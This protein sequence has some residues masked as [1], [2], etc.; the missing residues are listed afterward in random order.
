MLILS[1]DQVPA[2]PLP[3]TGRLAGVDVGIA[4]FATTSDGGPVH[5]PRWARAA[6]TRLT[7]AQH[8]LA[9]AKCGS[10]NRGR[11]LETVAARHRK[12]ANQRRDFHHKT[13]RIL[14]E[15]YDL[16]VVEDL[17]IAKCC[18][19]PHPWQTPTIPVRFL[20]N[21]AAQPEKL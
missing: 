12:I 9:R 6:A 4:T 2:A 13:A 11:R 16:I 21:G 19:G 17:A 7:A 8:R 1:C 5:N 10:N 20:P 14:V 3:A 18:D 15:S